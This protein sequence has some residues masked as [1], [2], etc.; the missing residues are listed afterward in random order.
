[1]SRFQKLSHT[2][3]MGR[4]KGQTS[5]KIFNQ[6]RKFREKPYWGN[7]LWSTGKERETNRA[8]AAWYLTGSCAAQLKVPCLLWVQAIAP[9]REKIKAALFGRGFFTTA[10]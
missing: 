3:M 8:V 2:I 1:M 5:M 9:Y 6:F 7:H 10:I 4:L